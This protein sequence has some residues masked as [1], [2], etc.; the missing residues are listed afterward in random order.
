MHFNTSTNNKKRVESLLTDE[1]LDYLSSHEPIGCRDIH[2]VNFLKEHNIDAYFSGCLTLTLDSGKDNDS[3]IDEGHVVINSSIPNE[4]Y[5]LIKEK[6]NKKIYF[7]QQDSYLH[8]IEP[9]QKQCPS[10]YIT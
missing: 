8:L 9:F 10:G 5:S 3:T 2:T 7:I 6:T 4:I 1:S